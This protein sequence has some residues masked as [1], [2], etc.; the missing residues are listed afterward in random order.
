[1]N[2]LE[3]ILNKFNINFDGSTRLP[4]EIP[5][6]GRDNLPGLLKELGYKTGVEIGVLSGDYSEKLCQANP[7]LKLYGVDPYEAYSQ[8]R[9]QQ[10]LDEFY[11]QAK[12][13]LAVFKN[14]HFVRQPSIEAAKHFADDSLD[15]VYIDGAHDL[16]SVL[17]DLNAWSPKVKPGGIISGHDYIRRREPTNHYVVQAVNLFIKDN[18]ISPWFLLGSNA[19]IPGMIR[20]RHRSFMWVKT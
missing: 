10:Q 13:K 4:I 14:Y 15:F 11:Q 16:L 6:V 1:M 3:Y 17:A 2:S 19:K 12:I 8:H 9:N 5:N 18:N 7:E 20:D